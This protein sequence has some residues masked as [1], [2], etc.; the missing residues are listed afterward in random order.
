VTWPLRQEYN[1]ETG[2]GCG[3]AGPVFF[4][5]AAERNRPGRLQDEKSSIGNP[6]VLQPVNVSQH[7]G[8]NSV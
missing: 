8:D 2:P 3:K 4:Y 5:S 7:F 1:L 6:A